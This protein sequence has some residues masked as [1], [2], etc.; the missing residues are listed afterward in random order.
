MSKEL[1]PTTNPTQELQDALRMEAEH[2][3]RTR[4]L[5]AARLAVGDFI[6]HNGVAK[7]AGQEVSV[8]PNG[9]RKKLTYIGSYL[10][11]TPGNVAWIAYRLGDTEEAFRLCQLLKERRKG[12]PVTKRQVAVDALD[13]RLTTKLT[14]GQIADKLCLGIG[15]ARCEL[16]QNRNRHQNN[17]P[18]CQAIQKAVLRLQRFLQSTT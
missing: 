13:M 12:R 16:R 3:T 2:P 11:E 1:K 8:A 15:D 17:T 9:V 6:K 7:A 5:W 18:C 14:W 10:Y 4:L